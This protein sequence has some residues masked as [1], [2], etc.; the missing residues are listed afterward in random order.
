MAFGRVAFDAHHGDRMFHEIQELM[1][2]PMMKTSVDD[3]FVVP[4][5]NRVARPGL[6][7]LGANFARNAPLL[8][9]AILETRA[10][11]YSLKVPLA[12]V[13]S[14]HADRVA[15]DIKDAADATFA[16]V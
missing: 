15:A 1:Q 14:V 6:Y 16:K 9:V 5:P 7:C 10:F 11:Q 2:V 13:R 12:Q 8:Q 3:A 4:L